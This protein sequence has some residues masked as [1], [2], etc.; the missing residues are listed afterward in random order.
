MQEGGH[1]LGEAVKSEPRERSG[2]GGG[3]GGKRGIV[4][5]CLLKASMHVQC[6]FVLCV[7]SVCVHVLHHRE[8]QV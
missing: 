2:G 1:L 4:A 6:S 7:M 5:V 8:S 3:G